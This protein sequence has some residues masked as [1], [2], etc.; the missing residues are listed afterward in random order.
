MKYYLIYISYGEGFETYG[1]SIEIPMFVCKTQDER[2]LFIDALENKENPYWDKVVEKLTE[3][4]AL[5]YIDNV[6]VSWN[7]VELLSLE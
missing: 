4:D 2:D 1:W 3:R 5:C 7:E 6:T